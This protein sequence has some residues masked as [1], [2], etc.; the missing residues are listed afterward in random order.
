MR[1]M[2]SVARRVA[3]N[4]SEAKRFTTLNENPMPPIATAVTQ[5]WVYK[6]V[7]SPIPSGNGAAAGTSWAIE[8]NEIVDPLVKMKLTFS[9]QFGITLN[10]L[11][12]SIYTTNY[13]AVYLVA[14]NEQ[15]SSLVPPSN[16]WTNYPVQ[17][18][19]D[20]PGWFLTQ[21]PQRPTL[22]GNNVKIIRRWTRK[23][24]PDEVFALVD[25]TAPQVAGYGRPQINF[26]CKHK[27]RGKKTFEDA[28]FGDTDS[29][30]LRAAI[31][32]GWNFYWLVGWGIG[33]VTGVP[34]PS[35]PVV[36]CDTYTYFKDP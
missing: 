5:R 2:K 36:S 32:R 27:F 34:T 12:Q 3:L 31:L 35:Q 1:L 20:D 23:Y 24:T 22:N 7:F 15:V 10:A 9:L 25:S 26:N 11:S 33:G 30:F 21:N 13:M 28:V 16:T 14:S 29:N 18:A 19:S 8:G 17:Y 4:L 6:N